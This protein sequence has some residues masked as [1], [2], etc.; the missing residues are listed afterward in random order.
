MTEKLHRSRY[1]LGLNTY[2]LY[3]SPCFDGFGAALAAYDIF[4]DRAKYIP[5]NY[6]QPPPELPDDAAIFILDFAF[7]RDVLLAW[8][9]RCEYITVIDHHDTNLHKLEGLIFAHFDMNKS[10][11]VLAWEFFH[12]EKAPLFFQ[13]LQDRDLW[14]FE[15]PNSH[16]VAAGL[17]AY[18]FDFDTWAELVEEVPKLIEMGKTILPYQ[19][20]MTEE[21]CRNA[22]LIEFQGYKCPVVNTTTYLSE[23]GMKLLDLYNTEISMFWFVDAKGLFRY[24]LRSK[25]GGPQVQK[26]A[27][28]YGGGGHPT[29]AGF[30]SHGDI[31][32]LDPGHSLNFKRYDL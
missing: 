8:E 24:S 15:L 7:E 27:E 22:R 23:V 9:K 21:A 30:V 18:K 11:A 32:G 3:H 20:R 17:K 5:V 31:F 29:S 19:A 6:G 1:P 4:G 13:Y 16:E 2:I 10:G 25:P 12:G 28:K 26:L 14:K